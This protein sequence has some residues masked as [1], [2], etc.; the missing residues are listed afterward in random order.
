MPAGNW[1]NNMEMASTLFAHETAVSHTT[2][3]GADQ[4][5]ESCVKCVNPAATITI[6]VADGVFMG[7]TMIVYFESDANAQD[8][9]VAY[10][11]TSVTLTV[12]TC[13]TILMWIGDATAGDWVVIK[14]KLT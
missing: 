1:Y 3:S 6:T 12:A 8:V 2:P 14:E 13:Y 5:Y 4:A 7:Q 9:V 10:N 11:A